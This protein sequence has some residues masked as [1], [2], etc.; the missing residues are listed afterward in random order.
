M[1]ATAVDEAVIDGDRAA[2]RLQRQERN[3][4]DRGIGNAQARPAACRL[5]GETKRVILKRLV[6]DPLIVVTPNANDALLRSHEL[7]HPEFV[8]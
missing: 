2:D 3:R 4:P 5:G 6:R 7:H 8:L 1:A